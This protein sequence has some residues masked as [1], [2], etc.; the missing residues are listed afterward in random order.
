MTPL[1]FAPPAGGKSRGRQ[2]RA[3]EDN[4]DGFGG[5]DVKSGHGSPDGADPR[6]GEV[7]LEQLRGEVGRT[8]YHETVD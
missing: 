6:A 4:R 3:E 2:S 7:H 8:A 1:S 5:G